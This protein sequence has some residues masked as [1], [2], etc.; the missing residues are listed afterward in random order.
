MAVFLFHISGSTLK[1]E[2]LNGCKKVQLTAI[3]SGGKGPNAWQHTQLFRTHKDKMGKKQLRII[4]KLNKD[5]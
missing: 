1:S 4:L 5:V 3:L 2:G